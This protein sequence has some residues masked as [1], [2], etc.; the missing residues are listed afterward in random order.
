MSRLSGI[1][2]AAL[3]I[4]VGGALAAGV[5]LETANGYGEPLTTLH[6]ATYTDHAA[7]AFARAD[8]D[9]D[10]V[11]SA[12]EFAADAIVDAELSRLNGFVAIDFGPTANPIP[13]PRRAPARL[14]PGERG[15]IEAAARRA[16]VAVAGADGAV[17]RSEYVAARLQ[18][19]DRADRNDNGRLASGELDA[20]SAGRAGL[21]GGLVRG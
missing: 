16:F 2:L 8:A 10:G 9:A 18:A 13:T 1:A 4:G 11:L 15:S 6:R 12:D 19:F 14:G 20:F 5:G 7:R 3:S 17:D 21:V